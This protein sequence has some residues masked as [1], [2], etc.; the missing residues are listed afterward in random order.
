MEVATEYDI[1]GI[2]GDCGGVCSCSTCHVKIKQEWLEKVG[3]A[4]EVE[5]D[6]L[7][8][9]ETTDERSRL[10]CQIDV[11]EA[12]NGLVVEVESL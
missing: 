4:G 12:L 9:E 6:M 3:A 1:E 8:L 11:V 7:D 2:Y 5:R 10:C